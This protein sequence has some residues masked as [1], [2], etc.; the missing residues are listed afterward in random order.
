MNTR[1]KA[2]QLV[3]TTR[4]CG[5]QDAPI[6]ANTNGTVLRV[7]S[8]RYL[9]LFGGTPETAREVWLDADDIHRPPTVRLINRE[10]LLALAQA[11]RP[12][13]E[14]DYASERQTA[15]EAAFVEAVNAVLSPRARTQLW[16]RDCY[17][18]TTDEMIERALRAVGIKVTP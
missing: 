5:P 14:Q 6:A 15:A 12:I 7:Q 8:A 17:K 2:G 10:R 1:I 16:E 18:A 3:Q 13:D 9:V 4:E 11:A